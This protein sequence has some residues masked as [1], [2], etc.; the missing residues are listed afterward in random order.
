MQRVL[1]FNWT[2]WSQLSQTVRLKETP[3]PASKQD[4]QSS[5]VTGSEPSRKQRV[6]EHD[7]SCG[8]AG[9]MCAQV[10]LHV[11]VVDE[12][13]SSGPLQNVVQEV[14]QSSV[15]S[16]SLWRFLSS[17]DAAA[18]TPR[19]FIPTCKHKLFKESAQVFTCTQMFTCTS[20]NT[21]TVPL[22]SSRQK[23]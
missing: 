5:L 12:G 15:E 21:W 9:V 16:V 19:T 23:C 6:C 22:Q 14:L 8:Q 17:R 4:L 3:P 7:G 1:G 20:T 11:G 18:L 2:N 10:C 13:P